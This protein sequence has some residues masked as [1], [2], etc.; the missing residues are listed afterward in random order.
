MQGG[1]SN[2][3][4]IAE[5]LHVQTHVLR[6]RAS[7]VLNFLSGVSMLLS[8]YTV[9]VIDSVTETRNPDLTAQEQVHELILQTMTTVQETAANSPL[10]SLMEDESI[11]MALEKDLGTAL[12]K[13]ALAG[14]SAA[15]RMRFQQYS[16]EHAH[17]KSASNAT[18]LRPT[19]STP[20]QAQMR[21]QFGD[22][23]EKKMEQVAKYARH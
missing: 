6:L 4:V 23:A 21:A 22:G 12:E 9:C 18:E 16:H 10:P 17:Q 14:L 15:E 3:D 2:P 7:E 20:E 8:P 5:Y 1:S 13:A 11:L 19:Y